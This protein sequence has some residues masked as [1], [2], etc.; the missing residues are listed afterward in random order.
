MARSLAHKLATAGFAVFV[1]WGIGGP[2][3]S[4]TTEEAL[5]GAL[6][7]SEDGLAAMQQYLD[8]APGG[9]DAIEAR[10]VALINAIPGE[11]LATDPFQVQDTAIRVVDAATQSLNSARLVRLPTVTSLELPPDSFAYEF[12]AADSETLSGFERITPADERVTG[13]NMQALQR[14]ADTSLGA[15][16]ISGIRTF[17]TD[18]PNG[19]YRLILITGDSGVQ[20]GDRPLGDEVI[21]N[22]VV[23]R[24]A[25]TDPE[26][27]LA[28]ENLV[29]IAPG[30]A[31]RGAAV[32]GGIIVIEVEVT[33]G[34]IEVGL[35]GG[36]GLGTTF[37]SGLVAEPAGPT[38][39]ILED[40]GVPQSVYSVDIVQIAA[41][42]TALTNVAVA[43][44]A[45]AASQIATAAG[46]ADQGETTQAASDVIAEIAVPIE[47]I[48]EPV[49]VSPN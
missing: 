38:P 45:Q 5:R 37:L 43:V 16:G 46:P 24:V 11:G 27:W 17:Q 40:F 36:N 26:D 3:W 42:Q 25:R 15:G 39:S 12:G 8:S 14:P 4:V 49:V 18:L 10:A 20:P 13:E 47:P 48:V 2:A 1:I 28:Y 33:N 44:I 41:I 30:D 31:P 6:S 19:R 21:V 22:G 35:L 9:A 32:G 23:R 29:G 7:G 34:I